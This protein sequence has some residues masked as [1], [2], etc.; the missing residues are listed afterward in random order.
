MKK[1]QE[2]YRK[3]EMTMEEIERSLYSWLGR[4]EFGDTWGLRKNIAG[5]FGFTREGENQ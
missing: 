3:G 4:A 2:K 1:F 5:R